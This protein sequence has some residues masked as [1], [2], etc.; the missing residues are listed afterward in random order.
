MRS[1]RR[2]QKELQSFNIDNPG[3]MTVNE[4]DAQRWEVTLN[5]LSGTIYAGE[6]HT[7]RITFSDNYP[8]ES[9]EVLKIIFTYILYLSFIFLLYVGCFSRTWTRTYT[10]I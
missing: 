2:L 10:Y 1:T 7:L 9:P 3:S 4:I 6:K 5:D 8:I